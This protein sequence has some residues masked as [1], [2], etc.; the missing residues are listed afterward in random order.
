MTEEEIKALQDKVAELTDA[1]ERITKNRDDIIGEKRDIQ[2]RIGEKDDALKLLAEEKLK[3]AG[4]MDGL[5]AMYAKDNVEALAKLQDALD[6]ERKSNRTIEYDKEFNSN[7]DMFHADHKVAGKAMLSNALQISYNDQGEKTTSYMHDGAEVANNAKDFQ[8]WASESG[9]YKQY[10]NG[11][12]SSGAD[13]T[14]S[15]A[16]GSNDG[17]TVQSKLAQRLK[18]AGL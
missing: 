18:Q 16:S 17:N 11:V 14:Q 10:L 6:G 13:T 15:R 5:K 1:N 2:S 12:D 7:V 9:V 8:S 4:D 3:L